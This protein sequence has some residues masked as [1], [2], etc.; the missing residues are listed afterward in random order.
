MIQ[1]VHYILSCCIAAQAPATLLNPSAFS[2][3]QFLPPMY[4]KAAT[5]GIQ[6]L[7]HNQQPFINEPYPFHI[8]NSFHLFNHRNFPVNQMTGAS[9]TP[10]PND[11][12]PPPKKSKKASR[13]GPKKK[14]TSEK[15][16]SAVQETDQEDEEDDLED[17]VSDHQGNNSK[18]QTKTKSTRKRKITETKTNDENQNSKSG[19]KYCGVLRN[20]PS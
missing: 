6:Q 17:P 10:E 5:C 9:A 8:P 2:L 13:G 1:S 19:N 4:S 14:H 11:A 20:R 7:I 12:S 18:S 15:K 16:Q 3:P